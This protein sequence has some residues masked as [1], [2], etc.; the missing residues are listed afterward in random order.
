MNR[1]QIRRAAASVPSNIAEGCGREGDRELARFLSIAAGSASE[2][3]YQLLLRHDLNFLDDEPYRQLD[4][5]INEIKRML[6][7]FI[8][9]LS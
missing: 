2:V 8:R 3:E 1:P 6:N 9:K 4:T 5:Q 7:A